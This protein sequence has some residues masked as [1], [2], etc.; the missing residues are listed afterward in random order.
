MALDQDLKVIIDYLVQD[1]RESG[2]KSFLL[3]VPDDYKEL[4]YSSLEDVKA[5]LTQTGLTYQ[6]NTPDDNSWR[7][8]DVPLT[9]KDEFPEG[10]A[11]G[12]NHNNYQLMEASANNLMIKV[13]F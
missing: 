11:L 6:I 1:G 9:R 5:Y 8:W 3:N 12:R 4:L 13:V 7:G 10:Y 2:K